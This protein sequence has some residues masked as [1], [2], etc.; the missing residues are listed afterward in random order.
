MFAV[1]LSC[2]TRITPEDY[3]LTSCGMWRGATEINPTFTSVKPTCT[4]RRPD[5][6]IIAEDFT[7]VLTNIRKLANL[8]LK[9]KTNR[10]G[11]L[12]DW[13]SPDS[14]VKFRH[15]LFTVSLNMRTLQN[16]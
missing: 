5:E 15:T 1:R 9:D 14:K 7:H 4:G 13:S 12:T 11:L 6:P 10:R 8:Q 3:W 16:I 2:I